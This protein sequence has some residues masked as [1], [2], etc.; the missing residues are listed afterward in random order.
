MNAK[1]FSMYDHFR[2]H[3]YV[4]GQPYIPFYNDRYTYTQTLEKNAVALAIEPRTILP[5]VYDFLEK[6][7]NKFDT[8]FTHDSI[9][10]S[11]LPNA[12]LILWGGVY[13]WSD[14]EKTKG[15][16]FCSSEK[17][18]CVQ[19]VK[20]L[21]LC[22]ELENKI[23]CMGTYNGGE[24]V[25]TDKIY[26]DYKFSVCIENYRDDWWFT[27]K[28]C[29]AFSNKCVP[30]YYGARN[31]GQLF[32]ESGIIIVENLND[33]P[34][35][36]DEILKDVDG[37]YER[38]RNAIETNYLRVKMFERFEDWFFEYY[39]GELEKLWGKAL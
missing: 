27:E 31:I 23:D 16:S 34:K 30:I 13:S 14:R 18:F 2:N 15:I 22:R 28:I 35:V 26:A 20:R 4:E 8:V 6:N 3:P 19:H 25:F 1:L 21:Q 9:L 24:R 29:N 36:V 39:K 32:D 38:R 11:C 10:L 33:L 37:E 17:E 5:D 7:Y 12:K